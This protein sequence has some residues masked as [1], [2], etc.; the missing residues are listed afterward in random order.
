[1]PYRDRQTLTYNEA[2]SLGSSAM[3]IG[4]A[5]DISGHY[6]HQSPSPVFRFNNEG[7]LVEIIGTRKQRRVL[8]PK[9]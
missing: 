4:R 6:S 9:G 7:E 8:L 1:M 3:S 2:V 5:I